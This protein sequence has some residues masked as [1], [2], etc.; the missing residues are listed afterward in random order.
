M[1]KKITELEILAGEREKLQAEKNTLQMQNAEASQKLI[2]LQEDK[3]TANERANYSENLLM[4]TI[5][6]LEDLKQ[7]M[8]D[9]EDYIYNV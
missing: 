6:Q 1:T 8:K 4:E 2:S 7:K 3:D 5:K 9:A